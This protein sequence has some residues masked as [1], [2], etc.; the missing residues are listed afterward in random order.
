MSDELNSLQRAASAKVHCQEF[1]LHDD[2]ENLASARSACDLVISVERRIWPDRSVLTPSLPTNKRMAI[3]PTDQP[4]PLPSCAS[5][6]STDRRDWVSVINVARIELLRWLDPNDQSVDTTG[7]LVAQS[8][9]NVATN[10]INNQTTIH[11]L[12]A[13]QRYRSDRRSHPI[14]TTSCRFTRFCATLVTSHL[15]SNFVVIRTSS[16]SITVNSTYFR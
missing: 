12:Q 15:A 14:R 11:S 8:D 5:F 4:T 9:S 10:L 2:L 13:E 7:L 3:G 16:D 1:D 6:A